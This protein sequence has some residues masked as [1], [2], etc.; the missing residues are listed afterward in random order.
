M[1]S[2]GKSMATNFGAATLAVGG[3]LGFTINKFA[4]FDSEMR[5][6]GAI[7]GANAKELDAMKKSAIELGG[8]TS[9]S[10]SSVASAMVEMSAKGFTANQTIAAMPGIIA[11]AE[12]SGEDLALA[13]DTV[14]SALNIWGLEAAESSRVADVLAMSANVSAAGITDLQYALKY[15][16]GPSAALGISLEELAASIGILVDSG[17]DGSSAGT[18][19]R[20]S[21]LALNNPAKAQAKMMDQLGFS[22]IDA[23]G[24]AKGLAEIVRDMTTSLE[25]MTEA[26]K[27]ATLAK[28]V[29]TEAVSGFLALMKAGPEV[30][31]ANTKALEN[32]GGAAAETAEQMKAGIG[33]AIEQMTGAFESLVLTIGDKLA[34][35]VQS[36]AEYITGLMEKFNSLSDGVQNFIAKG[37][38]VTTGVLAIGTGLGL[39]IAGVGAVISAVGTISTALGALATTFGITGGATGLLSAAFA[40]ITGPIGIAIAAITAIGAALVVAYN[41]VD[42]FKKFVDSAWKEIKEATSVAFNAVKDVVVKVFKD[43]QDFS[44]VILGKLTAFWKEHGEAITTITKI[45]FES[46]WGIIKGVM[47]YIQGIFQAV[48]PIISNTVL[49]AWNVIKFAISST[50][51]IILGVIGA[52]LKVLQ[53]DWKGAWESIK[54][55][56]EDIWNN[57]LRF[58]QNVSLNQIGKDI[59][60]GLTKGLASMGDSVRKAVKSLADMIPEGLKKFLGIHSPSRV[61]EALGGFTGEGFANGI[62]NQFSNVRKVSE[63]LAKIPQ[64]AMATPIEKPSRKTRGRA[65]KLA[66]VLFTTKAPK[67]QLN[68]VVL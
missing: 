4:D 3:A 32:S 60:N 13:A 9:E 66:A 51:D 68:E 25:G 34:P 58:F 46:T 21:L 11:A 36:M 62:V 61:T 16:G 63:D 12:A 20:A 48:W 2:F 30:I 5:K 67:F 28:L 22:I 31:E 45:A 24:N 19:L 10:A 65:K 26:E 29:G 64:E 56:G 40:A 44:Q 59:V 52:G 42:W 15:A 8:A 18:A 47:G 14:A 57:I 6:A 7:A 37:A 53:G 43:I 23:E 54:G 33:G 1:S 39:L 35:A 50:L 17:S 27:V 41:K 55:I 49:V 38:L